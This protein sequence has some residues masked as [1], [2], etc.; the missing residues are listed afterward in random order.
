MNKTCVIIVNFFGSAKTERCVSSLIDQAVDTVYLVD[1]SASPDESQKL[2]QFVKRVSTDNDRPIVRLHINDE[3]LGFGRAV[4]GIIRHDLK[5]SGGHDFYMV[6]NNDAEATPKMVENLVSI[7]E[8]NSSLWLLSP[9]VTSGNGSIENFRYS[10]LFGAT[11]HTRNPLSF[12]FLS[13]C[14]LVFRK[15][16]VENVP[17]FDEDFFMYGEDVHLSWRVQKQGGI[18]H[19]ARDIQ[20]IHEGTGSSH[21]G[22]FFY[23]HHVARGHVLL[24]L[25]TWNHFIEIPLFLT[26]R[27]LYLLLRACIRALRYKTPVP[28]LALFTCWFPFKVRLKS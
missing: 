26:G 8:Q 20:V 19:C 16:L 2:E 12:P 13:G 1:N 27:M 24:A 11:T 14:C 4:N 15:S 9:L 3:N 23:E 21:Y 28:I 5:I 18:I 10:R 6:I 7:I 22:G 25:K 17:L